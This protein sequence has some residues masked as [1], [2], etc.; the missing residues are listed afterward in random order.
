MN[1]PPG[2]DTVDFTNAQK[3]AEGL[4]ERGR[5]PPQGGDPPHGGG[6]DELS[7]RVGVL[8]ADVKE[9]K[10]DLKSL[11]KDAAAIK[12]RLAGIEGRL[13]NLPTTFQML[14]WFVGISLGLVGL[15]FTIARTVALH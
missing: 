6:L 8:E 5:L 3:W 11:V 1:M 12:E 13:S 10:V 2:S 14:T 15:V 7:R 9:I 4:A